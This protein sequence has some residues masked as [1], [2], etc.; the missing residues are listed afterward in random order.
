MSE[1]RISKWHDSARGGRRVE[2]RTSSSTTTV[3]HPGGISEETHSE[4]WLDVGTLMA[5]VTN[6]TPEQPKSLAE[7]MLQRHLDKRTS[8]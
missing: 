8:A 3:L 2:L 4:K 1:I 5:P 7:K 6:H